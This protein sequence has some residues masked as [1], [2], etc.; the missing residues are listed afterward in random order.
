MRHK[1][2]IVKRELRKIYITEEERYKIEKKLKDKKTLPQISEELDIKYNTLYKEVK[3]GTVIQRDTHLRDIKMYKADYAQ[4]IYDNSV[5]NRGRGLKIG[6]DDEM[7]EY[8]ETMIKDQKYSPQALIYQ[9]KKDNLPFSDKLC[10]KTIYN[11]LD[12]KL[13]KNI[14]N[15]DLPQKKDDGRKKKSK[16]RKVALNN[17][18]G[19]SIEKRPAYIDN[20]EEYGHWEMDTVYSAKESG[21]SC[22]LVLSER[23]M[24]EEI[25]IKISSR[26]SISVTNALDA[27]EKEIGTRA[28][29]KKFKTITC[30][31][32]VEF[33]NSDKIE[34]SKYGKGKRT[35][36][37][38]CHP[39]SSFERGTNENI[40]KM[41]RRFFPKGTNFDMVTKKQIKMVES[42]IN[43]YPREMF[44]GL[45]SNE[46][47][48]QLLMVA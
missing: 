41:I 3:R 39:F 48:N 25:I 14:S 28:F 16:K 38:Y 23:M 33:L 19:K 45:S 44:D 4:L 20:R 12:K 40:N 34:N 36:L 15:K 7:V 6:A 1:Q 13:F 26:K 42:W 29:K 8:I 37:Y 11:Y 30:D 47:K 46:M 43:N 32:G 2:K 24:R 18:K 31:N 21:K 27:L 22:L 5:A 17:I 9:A 10:F 35:Q